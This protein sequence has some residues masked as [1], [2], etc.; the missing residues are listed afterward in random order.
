MATDQEDGNPGEADVVKRDGALEGVVPL[1]LALGVVLVPVDAGLV[2][3]D[4]VAPGESRGVAD[5]F[6]VLGWR[7]VPAAVHPVVLGLGA[8]VVPVL[9]LVGVVRRQRP[10]TCPVSEERCRKVNINSK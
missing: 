8:D 10:A 1:G 4:V 5:E 3:G 2:C 6:P 9:L 7:Q